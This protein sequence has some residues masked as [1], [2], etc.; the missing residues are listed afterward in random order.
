MTDSPRKDFMNKFFDLCR[1]YQED[2]PP[3][4]IAEIL[5]DYADR[6]DS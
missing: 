3:E 5:R 4:V 2:L 1:K 6:L